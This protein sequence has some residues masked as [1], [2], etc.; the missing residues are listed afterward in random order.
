MSLY[1]NPLPPADYAAYLAL[2]EEMLD[3]ALPY[4]GQS[5]ERQQALQ[6]VGRYLESIDLDTAVM[7]MAAGNGHGTTRPAPIR[8]K[9]CAMPCSSKPTVS[10]TASNG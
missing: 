9:P 10:S 5:L 6:K 3:L 4:L 8:Q 7:L 2:R 1:D